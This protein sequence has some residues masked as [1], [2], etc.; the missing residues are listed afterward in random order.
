MAYWDFKNFKKRTIADKILRNKAFKI[1][2][3]QNYDKYQRGLPSV[4]Y[5]FFDKK[6]P[7]SGLANNTENIQLA[8]ELHKPNIKKF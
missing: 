4:V 3:D 6:S 8:D 1:V 5:N 2:S 7:E